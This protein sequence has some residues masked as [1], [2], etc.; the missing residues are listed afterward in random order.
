MESTE[1]GATGTFLLVDPLH[2]EA[3]CQRC[4][5][6]DQA[7]R[8]AIDVAAEVALDTAAAVQSRWAHERRS[9]LLAF[10]TIVL[11]VLALGLTLRIS[12]IR[13]VRAVGAVADRVGGGELDVA[14]EVGSQDEMGRLARH[15]TE[16][17]RGLRQKLALLRFVSQETLRSVESDTTICRGGVRRHIVVVFSDVL[18]FTALSEKHEPEQVVEM[19]NRLLHAQAEVVAH[20]GGDIDKFVGDELMARFDGADCELR[21]TRCV[22]ELVAA[23][24]SVQTRRRVAGSALT[25]CVGVNAGEVVPGARRREPEG[26]RRHRR[27]GEPRCEALLGGRP[28]AGARDACDPRRDRRSGRR[29][30]EAAPSGAR[31]RSRCSRRPSSRP[32]CRR[33]D[34]R[35]RRGRGAHGGAC[36]A[37]CSVAPVR[38]RG[39]RR[40]ARGRRPA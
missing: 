4:H 20:H 15:L 21:A 27:R 26:L 32:T 14:P 25:I 9:L 13:P 36:N 23:A 39:R 30:V 11:V 29:G 8:G 38:S 18:G 35:P 3:R 16:M 31:T 1:D 34:S 6:S 37:A 24:R 40:R 17:T 12:V 2:N 22:V 10:V 5:G 19:L 7:L 28:R 33:P